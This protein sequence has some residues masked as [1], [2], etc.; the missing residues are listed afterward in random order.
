[1]PQTNSWLCLYA[2]CQLGR[3]YWFATSGQ[4]STKSLYADTVK[5]ALLSQGYLP[6]N[7]YEYQ[8]GVKVHDCSGLIG[9][10]LTCEGV[11][12]PPTL[13]NPLK[14]QYSMFNA[15]CSNHSNNIK[16]FP[17]IPGTLVFH[18]NGSSKTHVGIYVGDF[19]DL[20][21]KEHI[22][23]V[24]EAMGHDWGVTTT[25]LSNSKWDSWGQL[26]CCTIDTI[27][28]QKFDARTMTSSRGPVQ[29]NVEA[30]K[31]FVV[32]P[33]PQFN[34]TIDYSKLK[35][36]RVSAMMFFGGE[37]FSSSHEKKTYVNPN[38]TKLVQDCNSAGL[39]YALYVNVRAKGAIDA[40]AECKTLY[41]VLAQFPPKLG[42]WLSLQF[43]NSI[44]LNNQILEI[45]YRYFEQWGVSAK[46]GLYVTPEQLKLIDW[47]NFESRF[48]LWM[49]QD[50]P[51]TNVDDELLTPEMFEVPD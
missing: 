48:Y 10:A 34:Q 39:P 26:D 2:I 14:N 41:Y 9:G 25:K 30:T 50:M 17:H 1:M 43:N 8:L 27:K 47:R 28:G 35:E 21:G 16:A 44:E 24:V 3:P 7:N 6:Y 29:I 23:E 51:V 15:D 33:S 31:P 19:V 37:L 38:L 40:D 18:S 11:D 22:E 4:I 13:R 49:I 5:P 20:D 36:A 12:K 42:I 32:T 46:C 45:Y